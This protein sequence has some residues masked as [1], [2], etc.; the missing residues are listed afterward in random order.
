MTRPLMPV[1]RTS[2][3]L[4]RVRQGRGTRWA[5]WARSRPDVRGPQS[6]VMTN[7]FVCIGFL[8]PSL[9]NAVMSS[10]VTLPS[11]SLT[12]QA[13]RLTSIVRILSKK[14]WKL[15][16]LNQQKGE[17]GRRKYFMI[18]LHERTWLLVIPN[19]AEIYCL[20]REISSVIWVSLGDTVIP[21]WTLLCQAPQVNDLF[22][23]QIFPHPPGRLLFW[24]QTFK[25]LVSKTK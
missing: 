8:R 1:T 9:P 18:N 17:N 22:L 25:I 14:N 23:P 5:R 19:L 13:K 6:S 10:A 15:H 7:G 20:G 12:G 16:F 21:I 2:G 4:R 3:P 11:H 24:W